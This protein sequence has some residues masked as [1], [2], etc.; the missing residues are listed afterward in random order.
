[1]HPPPAIRL[2]LVS[3]RPKEWDRVGTLVRIFSEDYP[4]P[5]DRLLKILFGPSTKDASNLWRQFKFR[6]NQCMSG[7]EP[8]LWLVSTVGDAPA[9]GK[10]VWL[11]SEPVEYAGNGP[12]RDGP[13]VANAPS[14]DAADP[15]PALRRAPTPEGF[16]IVPAPDVR[17]A[18]FSPDLATVVIAVCGGDLP[19]AGRPH[20]APLF[21]A[22]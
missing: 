21:P 19:A 12:G 16:T 4:A 9:P 7:W 6:M 1:D 3:L 2:I 8:R 10:Y 14:R 20:G 15:G 5:F 17:A 18:A 11:E 13:H 22:E